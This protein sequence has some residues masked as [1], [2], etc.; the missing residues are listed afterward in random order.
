MD[1]CGHKNVA[2]KLCQRGLWSSMTSVAI[3]TIYAKKGFERLLWVAY[4]ASQ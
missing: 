4:H 1:D 3:C 2:R